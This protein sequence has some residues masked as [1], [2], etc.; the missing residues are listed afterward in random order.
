L[1]YALLYHIKRIGGMGWDVIEHRRGYV[2]NY[3]ETVVVAIR[4]HLSYQL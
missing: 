2:F 4:T 3:W 1:C